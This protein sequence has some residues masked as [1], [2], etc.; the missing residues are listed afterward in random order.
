MKE[1]ER[2]RRWGRRRRR[3]GRGGWQSRSDNYGKE[4]KGPHSRD[5]GGQGEPDRDASLT[6]RLLVDS[7]CLGCLFLTGQK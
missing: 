2:R 4:G 1:R 6:V 3:E 5:A 7:G